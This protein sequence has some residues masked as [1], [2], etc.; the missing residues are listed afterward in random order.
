MEM[1]LDE[2]RRLAINVN[3]ACNGDVNIWREEAVLEAG[4]FS[5]RQ[6]HQDE[7]IMAV[8]S[9]V[10]AVTG[11]NKGIGLA[12]GTCIQSLLLWLASPPTLS[13]ASSF[14]LCSS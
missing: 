3:V 8:Q 7:V 13:L 12:I 6:Q 5:R 14:S 11:A 10:A 2:E 1:S 4:R 9:R